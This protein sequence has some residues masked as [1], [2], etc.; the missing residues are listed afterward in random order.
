MPTIT[1]TDDSITIDATDT[2]KDLTMNV[3][4]P[5]TLPIFERFA[6]LKAA[7]PGVLLIFQN[8]GFCELFHEDARQ[9]SEILGLTVTT[10][11]VNTARPVPMAGF[12]SH[13]LEK[14]LS[15]LIRSGCRAAICEQ[16]TA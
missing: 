6:E 9:A 5:C 3:A 11:G 8:N 14:H 1:S 2:A 7:H 4:T 16:A 15:K 10:W 12:P 13:E